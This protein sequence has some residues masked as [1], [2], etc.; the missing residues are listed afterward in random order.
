M[1]T[2]DLPLVIGGRVIRG[3]EDRPRHVIEYETGASVTIPVVTDAEVDA[4]R[5]AERYALGTLTLQEILA[6]VLRVGQFWRNQAHTNPLYEEAIASL[7]AING[8]DRKMAV[9][10]M[11]LI[12]S[13][14]AN[15]PGLYDMVE[16]EL[17]NR[18]YLDEWIPRGDA[19]VHTQPVGNLAHIMVGNV[20][21]SGVMSILRGILTKNA[22]IAKL[23][24]RDPITTTYL[25][26]SMILADPEHPVTRSMNVMYW[27]GGEG[28][29]DEVLALADVV[30]V[31]GGREAVAGIK[32][33]M[34]TQLDCVVFGPKTSYA[35]IGREAAPLRRTAL[36]LVHD[37]SLYDQEA[38]FCPQ[39]AFVEGDVD[40]LVGNA[41]EAFRLYSRM[42]PK[43]FVGIDTSARVTRTQLE[44][45]FQ[46][47]YVY[48]DADKEWTVIVVDALADINEHP[49]SRTLFVVPVQDI[50]EVL[51]HVDPDIQTIAIAPWDR[52]VE[53]RDRATLQGA[54]KMTA[55]GLVAAMRNGAT[56]DYIYPM[57]R[58]VRWVCVERGPEYWGK[59]I[60][61]GPVDSSRFLMQDTANP[62]DLD[63][64]LAGAGP[65]R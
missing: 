56:H 49:L 17:G 16:L 38:C 64:Y 1:T 11:N 36:D 61:Q 29:E 15:L 54:A 59:F 9:R 52:N 35:V 39:V 57:Q 18:L 43:A 23:P 2:I 25:A 41:V 37:V 33:K 22:T 26:L 6:F 34:T 44:A 21:V 20:P 8:Y 4:M 46:G 5:S 14:W 63:A 31:W 42:L 48:H 50:A 40:A 3:D 51:D 55:L 32:S 60:Y 7:C 58:Y 62:E 30:C 19:L 24:K 65:G 12:G 53:I 45:H 13:A 27:V 10:E 47:N 28:V